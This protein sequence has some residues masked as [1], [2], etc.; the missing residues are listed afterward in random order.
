MNNKPH[1]LSKTKL[2]Y[3]WCAIKKRCYKQN[4]VAYKNYG[5]RG[6]KMCNEWLNDFLSFYNWSIENGYKNNCE[7]NRNTITLDRI[8]VDKDY[9]PDNC[10][11]VSMYEQNIN[12]RNTLYVNYNG[13]KMPLKKVSDILGITYMTLFSR[14][15]N[16]G[17]AVMRFLILL[18]TLL[19]I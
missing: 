16:W 6:I 1:N 17:G 15:K 18:Q 7:G 11:W 8:D 19:D 14:I 2:Y 4:D 9:S 12:K 10:R 13:K 5:G 3:I